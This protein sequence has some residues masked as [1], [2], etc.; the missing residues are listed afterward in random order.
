[1]KRTGVLLAAAAILALGNALF[2]WN[3]SSHEAQPEFKP[4]WIAY[5][6]TLEDEQRTNPHNTSFSTEWVDPRYAALR[7]KED[8]RLNLL[9]RT[10]VACSVKEWKLA[11]YFNP[12]RINSTAEKPA[13]MPDRL[14]L[15]A[16]SEQ[17]RDCVRDDLPQG[18][19]L[20]KL[21]QPQPKVWNDWSA[22]SLEISEQSPNWNGKN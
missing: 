17:Q 2:F 9:V 19:Q 22:P 6:P 13:E 10:V 11:T 7:D 21:A 5:S 3:A 16:L 1:M 20:A 8:P 14:F 12:D 4:V 15:S 18:Y